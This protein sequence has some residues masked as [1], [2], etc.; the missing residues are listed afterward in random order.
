MKTYAIM[1]AFLIIGYSHAQNPK[2]PYSCADYRSFYYMHL[3]QGKYDEARKFW[4]LA[5]DL[6]SQAQKLD[7][8]FYQNGSI[9]YTHLLKACSE[10]DSILKKQLTDSLFW[11]W[12]RRVQVDHDPQLKLKFATMLVFE[13]DDRISKIDSLFAPFDSLVLE[14]D[15]I[16]LDAYLRHIYLNHFGR[17]PVDQRLEKLSF[18]SNRFFLLSDR[19]IMGYINAENHHDNTQM[20]AYEKILQR[21]IKYYLRMSPS[22]DLIEKYLIAHFDQLDQQ[23]A[24]RIQQLKRNMEILEAVNHEKSAVYRTHVEELLRLEPTA[25][26]FFGLGN[27]EHANGHYTE[28]ISAYER[29]L[30]LDPENSDQ[31]YYQMA[32]SYYADHH[33]KKAFY[34]AKKVEGEL[35]GKAMELCGKCIA[36]LAQKCGDSSFERNSNYWLANDYY[37]KAI[38]LGENLNERKFM[39]LAPSEDDSFKEGFE[40][41][42]VIE[43]PCWE[44]QTKVRF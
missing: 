32:C 27:I 15:I 24:I 7:A 28:A 10:Q 14:T 37:Q 44:E 21:M 30:E 9:I 33:Y 18:I 39:A 22:K 6:C 11:I 35:K 20:Q 31:Y 36:A 1:I 5:Y 25:A 42:D 38:A 43:C 29:A 16:V 4:L 8:T 3:D 34:N 19:A 13:K 12:D 2:S 26:G 23:E 17:T 40:T 41:G